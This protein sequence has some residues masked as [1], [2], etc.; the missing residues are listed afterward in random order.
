MIVA[1]QGTPT[2]IVELVPPSD[3]GRGAK[4]GSLV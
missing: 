1:E 3:N 4:D 2:D